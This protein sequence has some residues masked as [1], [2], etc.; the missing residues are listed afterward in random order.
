MHKEPLALKTDAP[1]AAVWDVMR[2]WVRDNPQ[3]PPVRLS[4]ASI[5]ARG[6]QVI[7]NADF[8]IPE[9][10]EAG[11]GNRV[12]EASG[13]RGDFWHVHN[14]DRDSGPMSTGARMKEGQEHET[15]LL[16]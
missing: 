6:P 14:P 10:E 1:D 15:S 3:P 12:G 16:E 5:I 8:H 4:G 13:G 2:C 7:T 11:L 9:Q